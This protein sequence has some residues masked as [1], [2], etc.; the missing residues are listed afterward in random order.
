[1]FIPLY[2]VNSLRHIKLQYVTI[3]LIAANVIVFLFGSLQ[4]PTAATA[5]MLSFGFIPSVV[6]NIAELPPELIVI[7]ENFSYITYSFLH[8]DIFHIGANML[9]LWVFGD[10][11]EDALGH[12][13]FLLFYL[14]CAAAGAAMHGLM[15]PDS[16]SP[17]IGASGAVAG[18]VTAY[19]F[20]HPRV[21]VWLLAFGRIPLPIPAWLALALWIGM[22]F[23]M[24][25]VPGEERVSFAAHV[26]GILAG[27]ALVLV[28]RRRGV[29]LFDRRIVT[30]DA[31]ELE[32]PSAVKPV[33]QAP[34]PRWGRQ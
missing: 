18:V 17:L 4:S 13:K 10:N 14:A 6:H 26:G 25:F 31:V 30:P 12:F 11:V 2:D 3:G 7:P 5:T 33:E 20:L 1:M 29:P 8:A 19:L 15:A 32:R 22:Q 28:L 21:R 27:A 16:Q 23:L 24:F 9:F 34:A